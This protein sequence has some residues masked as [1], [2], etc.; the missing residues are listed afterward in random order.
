M[1]KGDYHYLYTQ[2]GWLKR[3]KYQL[4]MQPCCELCAKRGLVRPAEVVDHIEPHR[5]DVNKFRLGALQSL[6]KQCHDSEKSYFEHR[7]EY[8]KAIGIDGW[9]IE[10]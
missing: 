8:R 9:P 2:V 3:R 5:G 10:D 6:C 1:P 7:G 4:Q